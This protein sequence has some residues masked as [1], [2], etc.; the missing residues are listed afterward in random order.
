MRIDHVLAAPLDERQ[1][2]RTP[3]TE[4]MLAA[5]MP[6]A[7]LGALRGGTTRR[8]VRADLAGPQALSAIDEVLDG[9]EK[10]ARAA[11]VRSI[12]FFYVP[13]EELALRRVLV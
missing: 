4:Q 9:A 5:L 3:A 7:N 10:M 12:A 2:V 11:G 8:P 13:P 6:N 1:I